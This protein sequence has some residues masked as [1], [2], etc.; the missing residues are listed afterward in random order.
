MRISRCKG[1]IESATA[2]GFESTLQL[3]SVIHRLICARLGMVSS[4]VHQG[5][6]TAGRGS[7]TTK[8]KMAEIMSKEQTEHRFMGNDFSCGFWCRGWELG[9]LLVDIDTARSNFVTRRPE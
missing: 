8:M 4:T 9:M 2:W 5:Q 3:A 6:K 1:R 7:P